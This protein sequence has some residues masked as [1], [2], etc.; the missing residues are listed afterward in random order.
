[1]EEQDRKI[2]III[3]ILKKK[4][5]IEWMKVGRG[6]RRGKVG[7]ERCEKQFFLIFRFKNAIF[8]I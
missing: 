7:G 8:S 1:M 5:F 6:K 3:I 2:I 4:H